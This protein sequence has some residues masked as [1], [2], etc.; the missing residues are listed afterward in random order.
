MR[1]S[2]ITII[3]GSAPS[4]FPSVLP[5]RLLPLRSRLAPDSDG[6]GR[7]R[8]NQKR[9]HR[10]P[11]QSKSALLR[12]QHVA[13]IMEVACCGLLENDEEGTAI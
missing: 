13:T 6:H 4:F 7:D 8:Q 3:H 5:L 9:L 10:R 1:W 12:M 11:F 2:A